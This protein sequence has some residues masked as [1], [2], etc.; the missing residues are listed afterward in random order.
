MSLLEVT[1]PIPDPQGGQTDL[2]NIQTLGIRP[3]HFA[4]TDD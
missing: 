2:S 3:P 1:E 4:R